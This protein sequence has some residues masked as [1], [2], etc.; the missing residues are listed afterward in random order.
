MQTVTVSSK[1]QIV[2]PLSVRE[3]IALRPGEKLE[4]VLKGRAMHLVPVPSLTSLRGT[5]RGADTSDV[6]DRSDAP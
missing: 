3:A 1:F 4:F 6:R 2:I 5:M